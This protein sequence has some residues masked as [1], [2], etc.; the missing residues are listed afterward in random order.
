MCGS[1]RSRSSSRIRY[2]SDAGAPPSSERWWTKRTLRAVVATV[3][4]AASTGAAAGGPSYSL[5]RP[6]PAGKRSRRK[7]SGRT[8]LARPIGHEERQHPEADDESG[9]AGHEDR[10]H[11]H[12][13]RPPDPVADPPLEEENAPAEERE[14]EGEQPQLHAPLEAW[15]E[16]DIQPVGEQPS[17]ERQHQR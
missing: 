9:R 11:P 2:E 6:L 14:A 5:A 3:S 8:G 1:K 15:P 17:D 12:V 13:N 4:E 10:A 7:L 16:Q